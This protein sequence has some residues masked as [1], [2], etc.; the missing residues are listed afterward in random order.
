MCH[1]SVE[2]KKITVMEWARHMEDMLGPDDCKFLIRSRESHLLGMFLQEGQW[3]F[4]PNAKEA[5]RFDW[6]E[7][8]VRIT[9]NPKL[10][11]IRINY[12]NIAVDNKQRT[13][14]I[15]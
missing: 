12:L 6:G 7:T 14:A 9:N 8:A 4:V 5:G 13:V 1:H 10:E 15:L 3:L 2:S 11:A